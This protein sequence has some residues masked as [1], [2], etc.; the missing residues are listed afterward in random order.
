MT[1]RK[2]SPLFL[3]CLDVHSL[4]DTRYSPTYGR[5]WIFQKNRDRK[6][7]LETSLGESVWGLIYSRNPL[8]HMTSDIQTQKE[9]HSSHSEFYYKSITDI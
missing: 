7:Q 3:Y 8:T 9:R 2:V 6:G 5:V 1:L 4:K